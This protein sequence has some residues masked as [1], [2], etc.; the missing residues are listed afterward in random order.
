[1]ITV[2][3]TWK[4]DAKGVGSWYIIRSAL[5]VAVLTYYNVRALYLF[6]GTLEAKRKNYKAVRE[7]KKWPTSFLHSKYNE[8]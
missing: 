8:R 5:K 3:L 7:A 2:S 4:C 6:M 1:M